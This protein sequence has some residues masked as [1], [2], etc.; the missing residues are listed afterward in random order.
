LNKLANDQSIWKDQLQRNFKM[1]YMNEE[2]PKSVFKNETMT[3]RNFING[4]FRAFRVESSNLISIRDIKLSRNCLVI[5]TINGQLM[6][7]DLIDQKAINEF[8]LGYS[9]SCF[10]LFE[11]ENMIATASFDR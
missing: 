8:Y 2:D 6:F 9:I 1:D 4:N 7:W 11:E 5:G 10:E 3:L